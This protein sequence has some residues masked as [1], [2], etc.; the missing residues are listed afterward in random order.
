MY[1][2]D[3]ENIKSPW[4]QYASGWIQNFT[5][6]G[7]LAYASNAKLIYDNK[8]NVY[9]SLYSKFGS[10]GLDG[11]IN[12]DLDKEDGFNASLTLWGLTVSKDGETP[13]QSYVV[14]LPSVTALRRR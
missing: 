9:N 13:L 10:N 5:A 8:H 4:A 3:K 14:S 11:V 2:V 7:L 6:A 12:L 1:F